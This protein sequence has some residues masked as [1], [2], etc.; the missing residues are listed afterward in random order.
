MKGT[1]IDWFLGKGRRKYKKPKVE[2][3]RQNLG[4]ARLLILDEVSMLGCHKLLGIDSLLQKVRKVPA[5]FGGLDIIFVG[6]FAQLDPV[7]QLSIMDAMVNTTLAYTQPSEYAIKTTALMRQFRKFELKE[8]CRSE[9]CPLLCSIL[10]RFRRT[11]SK[12]DSVTIKNIKDI[13]IATPD[14]FVS[15]IK[16]RDAPFLVATR[17][18]RDALTLRAGRIWA[19]KHGIPLY[20]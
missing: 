19:R 9:N 3:V 1:T 18:E 15:D 12:E 7:K 5:P 16:F 17:K 14:T 2:V 20:W 10:T 6:D 13:G 8:F 4:D 11:D